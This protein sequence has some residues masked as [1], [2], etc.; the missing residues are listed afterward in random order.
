MELP[1]KIRLVI[2]VNE[3]PMA[4]L[5]ARL[6]FPMM[7]RSHF[8]FIFGPSDAAGKILIS[9]AE[10][11]D[12]ARKS[13]ELCPM[14]FMEIDSGWTGQLVVTP[15]NLPS[16]G[17]ALEAVRLF[18]DFPFRKGYEAALLASRELLNQTPE[19]LMTASVEG[20]LPGQVFARPVPSR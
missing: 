14:D 11:R 12:E 7:R 5:L 2:R 6:E 10:L 9:A 8:E 3:L 4:G 15:V 1:A 13:M 19:G 20:E 18:K 16:A 17:N